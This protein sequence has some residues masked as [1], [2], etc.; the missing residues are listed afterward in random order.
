M[1]RRPADDGTG[2]L[3]SCAGS[4][5]IGRRVW[6]GGGTCPAALGVTLGDPATAIVSLTVRFRLIPGELRNV[7]ERS[8]RAGFSVSSGTRAPGRCR[9]RWPTRR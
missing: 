2:S 4:A 6:V 9:T 1:G 8:A 3:V 7:H 5:G